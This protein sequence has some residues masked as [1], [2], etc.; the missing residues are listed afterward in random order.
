M[1][2]KNLIE[3]FFINLQKL[4]LLIFLNYIYNLNI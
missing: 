1:Y 2:N 4:Y 3:D